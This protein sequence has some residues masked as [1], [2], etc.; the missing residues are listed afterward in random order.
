MAEDLLHPLENSKTLEEV[1][2]GYFND[3][4]SKSFFQHSGCGNFNQHFVMHVL[5]H[6]LATWLGGEFYFRTEVLGKDTKIA[7]KTRHLSFSK[8]SDPISANFDIFGRIKCLRTISPIYLWDDPFNKEKAS[9]SILSK[10]K[11]LRVLKFGN[12]EGLDAFLDSID[13]LIHLRYLDLSSTS[14]KILPESLCNLYNLQTLKLFNCNNLTRLPN[15]MQN[16]V[17]LHNLEI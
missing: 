3:L 13:E 6:D 15:D 11:Y 14:I 16:L 7:T 1:G 17:N 2:F 4:A 10:L 8:F 12:F 9:C 5:V